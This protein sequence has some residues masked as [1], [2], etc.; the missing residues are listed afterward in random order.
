MALSKATVNEETQSKIDQIE[1]LKEQLYRIDS[2]QL[3]VE[4]FWVG[5]AK[6]SKSS[7]DG[8]KS[9]GVGSARFSIWQGG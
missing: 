2:E 4:K 1:R 7:A 9:I 3:L 5:Y 8:S 6:S